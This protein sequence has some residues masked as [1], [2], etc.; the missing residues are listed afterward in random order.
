MV[1]YSFELENSF[2]EN[3]V[4]HVKHRAVVRRVGSKTPFDVRFDGHHSTY[5]HILYR[6]SIWNKY[7]FENMS[8]KRFIL[9]LK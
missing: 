8:T 2:T 4:V 9:K 6:T 5:S 7:V 3:C 1:G